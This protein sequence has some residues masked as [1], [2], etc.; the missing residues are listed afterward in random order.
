MT[1][2]IPRIWLG[3]SGVI[4][5]GLTLIGTEEFETLRNSN[6]IKQSTEG[7]RLVGGYSIS[8]MAWAAT[9]MGAGFLYLLHLYGRRPFNRSTQV[10]LFFLLVTLVLGSLII[11]FTEQFKSMTDLTLD[12]LGRLRGAYGIALI[13]LSSLVLGSAVLFAVLWLL[14]WTGIVENKNNLKLSLIKL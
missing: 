3:T 11:N 4:L 6:W 5:A 2:V 13:S 9:H 10:F 7:V 14:E 1:E 8:W 12:E